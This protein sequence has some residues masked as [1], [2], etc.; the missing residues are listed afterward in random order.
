MGKT[1]DNLVATYSIV[2]LDPKTGEIGVATQSKFLGVGAVVPWVKANV[3]AVATQSLANTSYGPRGLQMMEEGK[4]TQEVLD[5]LVKDDPDAS[6]RQVG[7]VDFSGR[8]ATFTGDDCYDWA[9]G[10]SGKNYAAQGNILVSEETVTALADTFESTERKP[11]AERLLAALEAAQQAGGDK[12]GMQSAA[13]LIE[14][15]KG[16]YGG[17]ND[18]MLDLR[19]DEHTSPIKEL[20]RIYRLYQLYFNRTKE[21]NIVPIDSERKQKI[22]EVLVKQGYLTNSSVDDQSF[23]EGLTNYIHTENF[24]ERE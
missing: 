12:R 7:V 8:S 3:G 21:G 2:G 22:A 9:G 15:E 4:T 18:R 1:K 20:T 5:E 14:K 10:K 11:L 24:E 17:Y 13:I 16:G 6:L 19:V 23:Y